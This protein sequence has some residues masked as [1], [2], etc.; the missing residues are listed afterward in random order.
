MK[1]YNELSEGLKEEARKLHPND[2]NEWEYKTQGV[3]IAFCAR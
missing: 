2:Y 1:K 3:E